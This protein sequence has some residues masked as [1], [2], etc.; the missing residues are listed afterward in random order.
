MASL[1]PSETLF[2]DDSS[3]NI[4]MAET[5]GIKTLLYNDEMNLE[6]EVKNRLCE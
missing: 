5:L 6:I 3:I 2:I 4:N 1:N